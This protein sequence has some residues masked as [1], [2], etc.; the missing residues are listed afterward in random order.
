LIQRADK[1]M[2]EAKSE[3]ADH[4]HLVRAK[5]ANGTIVDYTDQDPP[6][7]VVEEDQA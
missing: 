4:I 7:E 6:A 2:Y 3:H 1:L 5:L